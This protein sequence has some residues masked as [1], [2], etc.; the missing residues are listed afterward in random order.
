MLDTNRPKDKERLI[1]FL[2]ECE[3]SNS[4]LDDILNRFNLTGKFDFFKKKYFDE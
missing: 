3:F 4:R 2:E 1:K